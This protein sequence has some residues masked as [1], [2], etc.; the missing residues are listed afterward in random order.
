MAR[1][2]DL[3][4][5]ITDTVRDPFTADIT[6]LP[7]ATATAVIDLRNGDT[8]PIRAGIVRKTLGDATVRMLAYNGSIPGPTLR[9]PQGSEVTIDVANETDVPT[10]VHWH[11]LRLDNR[12]DGVPH[13]VHRGM[14]APIPVGGS[15]AY[16]LRFPDPGIY[17]YH[18]HVRED[19]T[20][21]LGLYGN[22]LVTPSDPD[23]WAPVD[24]ELVVVLDDILLKGTKVAPF[25]RTRSNR[26]AMGR[27]GNLMLLNGEANATLQARQGEVI[28]LY[29]TNTANVR[30]FNLRIPGA[31]LKLVGGDG[32]RIEEETF[33][34][35]VLIAP[36]ERAVVDV[37][38]ETAGILPI[39][40]R[41]PELT[42]P[43]GTIA[44]TESAERSP[45][46]EAFSTRR[47][48]GE[49]EA[50]R[51][52]LADDLA[53]DPD[54]HLSLVAV[55]PGMRNH[56][57]GHGEHV[58]I[59]WEDTMQLH[60]RMTTPWSMF[61]KLVDPE[62]GAQN[63]EIR[64][65]FRTGDRIKVRIAND[66]HSDH[67]MQ[68]PFHIHG[69]RFLVIARDGTPADNLVWKDSVLIRTGETVDLLVDMSNPG[70][71]MAHCHIA[72]HLE[73]GMML[74]FQVRE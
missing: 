18:P 60:N 8:Y 71:W 22:I 52:R 25:S 19:Y 57:G 51:A 56:G 10:T 42:R 66:P 70:T 12:F 68:H 36:S 49:F 58:D 69:E 73:G 55:M 21:E 62:T 63:Q 61:W 7:D 13:G 15:F 23:Y 41:G 33:V 43:L 39:E 5:A 9:V 17:W 20:Q 6:G 47:R 27:Y 45:F 37:L 4:R 48:N 1:V 35:E 38:F 29:L 16:R 3:F 30:P 11:G 40:H 50:E 64:W 14:Q 74:S 44:V 53:R 59:E 65:S 72:E 46:V 24:R 34:D 28:R 26:T 2:S 31:Q 54:K 67:P 32:G